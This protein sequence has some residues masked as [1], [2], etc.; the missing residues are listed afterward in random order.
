M[1]LTGKKLTNL[2]KLSSK[3]RIAELPRLVGVSGLTKSSNNFSNGLA[4]GPAA[5]NPARVLGGGL[6]SLA[7]VAVS[8]MLKTIDTHLRPP[9][10]RRHLM[11]SLE[12]P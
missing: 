10:I 8:Y 9:K 12:R 7:Q 2:E 4:V 6:P 1:R 5:C 11:K 3:T